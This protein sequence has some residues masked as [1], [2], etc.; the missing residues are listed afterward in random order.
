LVDGFPQFPST[1]AEIQHV[2]TRSQ[3]QSEATQQA[4]EGKNGKEIDLQIL[5]ISENARQLLRVLRPFESRI[6]ELEAGNTSLQVNS[7]QKDGLVKGLERKVL[8]L[9]Q[10][11][12]DRITSLEDE[13]ADL[14]EQGQKDHDFLEGIA[15]AKVSLDNKNNKIEQLEAKLE[16]IKLE[17]QEKD[18]TIMALRSKVSRLQTTCLKA[19]DALA[20]WALEN[21]TL[22]VHQ[23]YIP[24]AA[25]TSPD[26]DPRNRSHSLYWQ[27][28]I[29][30]LIG[31]KKSTSNSHV[32]SSGKN[33]LQP[34]ATVSLHFFEL[35][36]FRI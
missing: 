32:E 10:D 26:V 12:Q 28:K 5:A 31:R 36:T 19:E 14:Q 30:D 29:T 20:R 13:I 24:K 23:N 1:K 25:Y 21:G 9:Q 33:A 34:A 17:T 11:S 4:K 8:R 22:D 16:G 15:L 2:S 6:A 7:R 27:V 35:E 18:E 3:T